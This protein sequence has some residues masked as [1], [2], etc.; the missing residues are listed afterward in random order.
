MRSSS[1]IPRE[2]S[3]EKVQA[4][5]PVAANPEAAASL[6]A[7]IKILGRLRAG[8]NLLHSAEFAAY[9]TAVNAKR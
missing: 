8:G 3:P 7:L 5:Q 9:K 1:D 4:P 2:A 6:S